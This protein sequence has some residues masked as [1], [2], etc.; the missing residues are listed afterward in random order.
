MFLNYASYF[1]IEESKLKE[2][3]DYIIEEHM[4]DGGFNCQLRR[5]GAVHSSLHSTISVLEG[6][7][8]YFRHEYEYRLDELLDIKESAIEF[9]LQHRLYK[10]DKTGEIIRKSFTMLSYP[11]RW[12]YDILRC[13]E[14]FVYADVAY[15]VRMKD[16]LEVIIDKKRKDGKWTVQAKHQGE[17]FFE[18][19]KTGKPSRINTYRALKVLKKYGKELIV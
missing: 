7:E 6:I 18:L 1:G 16:A 2:I 19:E 11:S 17:V 9:I 3:V 12:Y 13:M 14:Y 5:P 8:S 10:S 4:L 15:D